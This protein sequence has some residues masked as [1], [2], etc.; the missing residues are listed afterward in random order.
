MP[1]SDKEV[2]GL[3]EVLMLQMVKHWRALVAS[4]PTILGSTDP[5]TRSTR[6]REGVPQALFNSNQI[7]DAEPPKLL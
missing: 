6:E 3:R 5:R 4:A 7:D 1:R 2:T